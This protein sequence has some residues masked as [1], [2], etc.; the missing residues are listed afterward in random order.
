MLGASTNHKGIDL[1]APYGTAILASASGT[2]TTSTHSNSAGNYIVIAHGNGI[3]T[4]YMHCSALLVSVGDNVEQGEII[5]R[6]G[7]TGYSSGNHLHFGV[8]KNG[9]YVDPLG[10]ISD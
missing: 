6:V 9:T 5:A 7:S 10:Y 8:I 1:T 2:V 4:V 3:S